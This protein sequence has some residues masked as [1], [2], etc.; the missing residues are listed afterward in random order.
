[1][2]LAGCRAAALALLVAGCAPAPPGEDSIDLLALFPFTGAGPRTREIRLGE[3]AGLPHLLR[4]WSEPETLPDGSRGRRIAGAEGVLLF[5]AGPEP[6]PVDVVV[7]RVRVGGGERAWRPPP[8]H[9]WLNGISLRQLASRDEQ[10]TL[11]LPAAAMRPG[12]NLLAIRLQRRPRTRRHGR[13]QARFVYRSVKLV[14]RG[15]EPATARLVEG[16]GALLLPPAT[17]VSFHVR[18]PHEA[19]LRLTAVA[20]RAGGA[21][22]LEIAVETDEAAAR[23]AFDDDV[24]GESALDLPLQVAAGTLTRITFRVPRDADGPVEI[25][26]PSVLGAAPERREHDASS[27]APRPTRPNVLLYVADTLRADR[28]GCYGREADVSPRLDALAA[29][30]IVFT[31]AVAQSSWTRPA[32]ASI[33]TGQYPADHGAVSLRD[34]LSLA[35]ETI[36]DLFGHHGYATGGFVTNVNVGEAFGFGRGFG[37]YRYLPEDPE[38]ESVYVP[39]GELHAEALRWLDARSGPFLLYVHATDP[40]APYRPSAEMASRFVPAALRSSLDGRAPLHRLLRHPESLGADDVQYL[41]ALYEAEVAQLDAEIGRLLDALRARG[42][43]DDTVVVFVADHGEEFREHGGFEHGSTLYQEVLHVPLIVRVPWSADAGRRSDV[44]ARQVDVLP[45]LLTLAGL[46][47]PRGLAGQPLLDAAGRLD[48]AGAPETVA[49]TWFGRS[50]LA[51]LVVPPWKVILPARGMAAAEVYDL[52]TDPGETRDVVAERPVTAGYAE[53]RV[54]ELRAAA[55]GRGG[56]RAE[57]AAPL[58]AETLERLRA[59]G[60]LD[61]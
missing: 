14:A 44:L 3:P 4:G 22:P 24:N 1:M 49:E 5:Q 28:L 25:D 17:Q 30:G 47:V 53:Q 23:V 57:D 61:E 20:P 50:A 18:A 41:R 56:Q 48:G 13:T 11:P 12:H 29:E 60:Y 45:T 42:H 51:A 19:R 55:S 36:A 21:H 8:Q 58:D 9:L 27:A 54:A 6:V 37:T 59:L 39:A 26:R 52:R 10:V 40:H 38:S 16:G 2:T 32:T 43:G 46:P 31:N 35:V 34:R 33:L 7:D 15:P